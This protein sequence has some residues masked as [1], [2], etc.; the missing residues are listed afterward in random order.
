MPVSIHGKEYFTVAERVQTF[1]EKFPGYVITTNIERFEGDDC[2]IKATILNDK[3]DVAAT[4]IAHEV[5]GSTNINRTS[6]VENCE[7]V[8]LSVPILTRGGWK[9]YHQLTLDEEVLAYSVE[10]EQLEWGRLLAYKDFPASPLVRMENTRFSATC[11][12]NHKWVIDGTLKELDSVKVGGRTKIRL[13]APLAERGGSIELAKKMGW[14][15]GDCRLSYTQDGLVSTATIT[16]SKPETVTEISNLFG[17]P[18][19]KLEGHTRSWANGTESQCLEHYSW[20]VSASDVRS[21]LGFFS[22]NTSADLIPA[23]CN[24]SFD[25]ITAFLDA[26]MAADGSA[27]TY[28]K[29][30]KNLVEAT[31]LAMFL[32]GKCTSE[33]KERAGNYMTTKP[34]Y[35][36]SSQKTS[37]KYMSELSIKRIPP[38][39]VWCPTTTHGTW[40]GLFDGRPAITGNTSAIGRALAALGL[41][42]TE[43][44]SADEVANAISNQAIE[45]ATERLRLHNKVLHDHLLEVCAIK[46]HMI[47]DG[48]L[49]TAAS[50]WFQF[51][52]EVKAALWIAPRD[53]GIF[54]TA[55]REIMKSK[56]FKD[57]YYQG[58][59]V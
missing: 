49:E 12:P 38:Q 6:H 2:I 1:L 26:V 44:A 57:A 52:D 14:L 13:S 9:F 24:M 19:L 36:V 33:I 59:L 8:P 51:D 4:G 56:E 32:T 7:C 10:S 34:C 45:K 17:A 55:E 41:A 35:T 54:T 25:E 53:G 28:A 31:Q 22:V 16:Q 40:V 3:G 42:G 5:R 15:F 46:T 21:T 50:T 23:L 18:S 48:G 39:K 11:T 20:T 29:T 37:D 43:Y 47:L 30:D 27:A 58:E